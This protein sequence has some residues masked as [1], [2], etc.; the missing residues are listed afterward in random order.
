MRKAVPDLPEP[1]FEE[2][3]YHALPEFMHDALRRLP[4]D[5]GTAL[6]IAHEPG[7]SSYVQQ[8]GGPDAP[9]HCQRAYSHFPTAA[10][11]VLRAVIDRWEDLTPAETTFEDFAVPRELV[12]RPEFRA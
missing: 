11:A 3:L 7:L 8:L 5:C 10:V 6:L 1:D 12:E 2:A 4:S 9:A